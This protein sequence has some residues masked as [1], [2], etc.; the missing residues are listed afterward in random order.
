MDGNF[1]QTTNISKLYRRSHYE[2][3]YTNKYSNQESF[4]SQMEWAPFKSLF[5]KLRIIQ[6]RFSLISEKI[7]GFVSNRN[8]VSEENICPENSN[9]LSDDVLHYW[10][11]SFG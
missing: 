11:F 1:D 9:K 4:I 8:M 7:L 6:D 10:I 5:W 3:V 2:P